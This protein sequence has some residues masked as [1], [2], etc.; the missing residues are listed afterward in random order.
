MCIDPDMGM[1][2]LKARI[3]ELTEYPYNLDKHAEPTISNLNLRDYDDIISDLRETKIS[4]VTYFQTGRSGL[5]SL[6]HLR[7][8]P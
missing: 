5:M 2:R 3:T 4:Q 8:R 7:S 1:N 6:N